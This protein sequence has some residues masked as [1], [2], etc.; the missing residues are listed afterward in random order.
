[1]IEGLQMQ[2]MSLDQQLF[3][4]IHG[5]TGNPV[6]DSLML[7]FAEALA[8]LI[9]VTLVYLWFESR[10]SRRDSIF[11]FVT[12]V[13]GIGLTY[14]LG[15]F[16]FHNQP[17]ATYDTIFQGG[18]LDNA[19]P[20]QHTASMFSVFW[21]FLYLNRRR[22]TVLFG[23][24]GFL[25]G[26]GRIFVGHHYP[27]DV[28]GGI[29]SGLLGLGVTVLLESSFSGELDRIVDLSYSLQ[30]SIIDRIGV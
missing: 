9:P 2:H 14:L 26:L 10:E 24:I 1:M 23:V 3:L 13:F 16:Y 20:S 25:T 4:F 30:S 17:F 5:F 6:L 19:F 18:E 7:F 29:F 15:I 12:A 28:L 11:T 22:L 21:S 27:V 8:F